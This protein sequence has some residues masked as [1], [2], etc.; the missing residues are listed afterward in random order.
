MLSVTI[1]AYV[2]KWL[3]HQ[4]INRISSNILKTNGVML[5]RHLKRTRNNY[6]RHNMLNTSEDDVLSYHLCAN[7]KFPEININAVPLQLQHGRT[8][9]NEE[10]DNNLAA[11]VVYQIFLHHRLLYISAA[12]VG[13]MH[14]N[15][16]YADQPIRIH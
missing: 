11:T 9:C 16:L 7:F 1:T 8:S 10:H 3:P 14:D 5:C 12:H 6:T 4:A 2:T 15:W 13:N